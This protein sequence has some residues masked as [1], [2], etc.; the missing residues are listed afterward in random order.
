LALMLL[1]KT[2]FERDAY[3]DRKR[4][5]TILKFIDNLRTYETSPPEM[6]HE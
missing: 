1:M 4:E 5:V 2:F 6:C 3:R